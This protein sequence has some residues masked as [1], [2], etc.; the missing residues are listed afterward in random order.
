MK[1]IPKLSS[2]LK[3]VLAWDESSEFTQYE[4]VTDDGKALEAAKK[5]I[6]ETARPER[7]KGH[8]RTV[9]SQKPEPKEEP[10]PAEAPAEDASQPDIKS[11]F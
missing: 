9:K 11:F 6:A 7:G 3:S 5:E 4:D 2:E 8:G 10:E 1:S